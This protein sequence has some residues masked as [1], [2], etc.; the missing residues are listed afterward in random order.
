MI[1]LLL[2]AA[3]FMAGAVNAL[4]GGGSFFSFPA[5]IF[6]GVPPIAANATS[7]V[8]LVPGSFASAYTF[9]HDIRRLGGFGLRSW[10]WISLV[11]GFCGSVLLMVTPETMFV[12][13]IPWLL[14]FATVVFAFGKTLSFWVRERLKVGHTPLLV[15]LFFV[16]VYGGYFGGGMSIMTLA[17][18]GLWGLTDLHA[19]NGAKS[20]LGA[21]LNA[22]AIFV[23]A[24]ARQIYWKHA[25]VMILGS[26]A[27]G[28]A[29]ATLAKRI[30][31]ERLRVIVIGAGCL[32]TIYFFWRY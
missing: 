30:P 15:L 4:A 9:R 12:R 25:L 32:M 7:T 10:L 27:G 14:C 6:A 19:M 29:G 13:L 18:L 1:Y 23:F 16:A 24:Y 3:A 17:L 11:G 2:V 8:A 5:L 28:V 20:L 31:P 26:I 22:M 21:S